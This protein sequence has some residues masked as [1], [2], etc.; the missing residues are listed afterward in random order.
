MT[1]CVPT[2]APDQFCLDGFKE[3]LNHIIVLA[4]SLQAHEDLEAML[5]Q[6]L[7]VLV[8]TILRPTIRVMNAALRRLSQNYVH[9]QNPDCHV[10]LHAIANRNT[11]RP[12]LPGQD[13]Q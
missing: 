8:G 5:G 1:A 13:A 12:P 3:G 10:P 4:I 6:E 9:F 2:V 11:M 7:L